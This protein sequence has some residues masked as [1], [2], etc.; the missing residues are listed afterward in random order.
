MG[1]VWFVVVSQGDLGCRD[2]DGVAIIVSRIF[3]LGAGR[4]VR[5]SNPRCENGG[6]NCGG[7]SSGASGKVFDAV[8]FGE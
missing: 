6:G 2:G 4:N 7:V 5:G 1:V 8:F 3:Q